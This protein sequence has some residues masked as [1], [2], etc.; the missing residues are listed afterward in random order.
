[1]TQS[2]THYGVPTTSYNGIPPGQQNLLYQTTTSEEYIIKNI[3]SVISDI[4]AI[5]KKEESEYISDSLL[6]EIMEL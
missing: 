1:M 2:V 6:E 3:D 5:H 4:E